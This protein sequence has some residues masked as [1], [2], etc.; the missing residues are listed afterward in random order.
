[1]RRFKLGAALAMAAV[2][3]AAVPAV[4]IAGPPVVNIH[5][6]FTSDPYDDGWCGI[7]GTSVDEV[8]AHFVERESGAS[9]ENLN[10]VITFTAAAS[11]KSMEIHIA[12]VSKTAAPV[13]NGDGDPPPERISLRFTGANRTTVGILA[14]LAGSAVTIA[15]VVKLL[16]GG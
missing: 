6:A 2:L 9:I 11:G 13:D 4:A 12:R 8:S 1:M 3:L 14:V 16:S 15:S 7:D 10:L 5:V